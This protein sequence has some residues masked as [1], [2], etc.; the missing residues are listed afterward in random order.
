STICRFRADHEAALS[1]LF[2]QILALCQKAGLVD[3]GTSV[4]DGTKIEANASLYANKTLETVRKKRG[5]LEEEIRETERIGET[6]SPGERAARARGQEDRKE[7]LD[8][9]EK[10]LL[11]R[12]EEV[13]VQYE[14]RTAARAKKEAETGKRLRGRKPKPAPSPE[15]LAKGR[16]NTTDP[17][18]EIMKSP[19]GFV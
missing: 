5:Y 13:A 6:L 7:R 12:N 8:A 16:I 15:D 1:G 19:K 10:E 18:S 17:D 11:E 3:P 9:C 2:T 4:V 14:T